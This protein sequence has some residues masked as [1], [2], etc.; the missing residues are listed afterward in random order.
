VTRRWRPG[1][2][3]GSRRC[4]AAAFAA[5]FGREPYGAASCRARHPGDRPPAV[6]AVTR[7]RARQHHGQAVTCAPGAPIAVRMSQRS[8]WNAAHYPGWPLQPQRCFA[9]RCAGR[10]CGAPLTLETSA[11]P[12][13]LTARARP[14]ARPERAR[15]TTGSGRTS[16]GPCIHASV[17]PS[18]IITCRSAFRRDRRAGRILVTRTSDCDNIDSCEGSSW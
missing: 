11:S 18:R 14:K 2:T 17:A 6:P 4:G 7:R 10:A 9:S 15:R 13:G 1:F 16:K 3:R 8:G 12:A 5:S